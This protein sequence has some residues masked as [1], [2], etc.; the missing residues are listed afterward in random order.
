MAGFLIHPTLRFTIEHQI[1]IERFTFKA[2]NAFETKSI[3]TERGKVC[4]DIVMI[5][6]L[7]LF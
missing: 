6:I 2:Q 4:I 5:D 1:I 3:Q 7:R